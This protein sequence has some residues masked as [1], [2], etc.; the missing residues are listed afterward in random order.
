MARSALDTWDVVGHPSRDRPD[1]PSDRT[2]NRASPVIILGFGRSGTTWLAD[3]VSKM[4]GN[5]ILFEPLHPSVISASD[6]LSYSR[7]RADQRAPELHQH[8]TFVLD[9]QRKL[10]W[11]L[12][13]HL[14]VHVND[15]DPY[16]MEYLWQF[17]DIAGF[18]EIRMNFMIPWLMERQMGSVLFI[19]RDPRAVISSIL[20]RDNFWEFGWPGTYEL[21]VSNLLDDPALAD[22]P[23]QRHAAFIRGPRS[24]VERIA[25]MWALTHAVALDDARRHGVP[26]VRYENLYRQPFEVTRQIAEWLG[27]G[28]ISIHP[29]Y[30]FAPSLTTNKAFKSIFDTATNGNGGDLSFFWRDALSQSD[31][32]AISDVLRRFGLEQWQEPADAALPVATGLRLPFAVGALGSSGS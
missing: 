24:Y 14:P 32:D 4:I 19:V 27:L 3:I 31:R 12:R 11:L 9:K 28:A 15:A 2:R 5:L 29:S 26:V 17:C 30:L 22:H 13:N 8:L 20:R 21:M 25:I 16:F 7:P 23:I 18:K 10:P 6:A 1:S